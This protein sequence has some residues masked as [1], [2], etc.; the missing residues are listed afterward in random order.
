[1]KRHHR[2]RFINIIIL[3]FRS[4]NGGS[5]PTIYSIAVPLGSGLDPENN[6][7]ART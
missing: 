3:L 5:S 4:C 7:S 2:G 6:Y 1:M